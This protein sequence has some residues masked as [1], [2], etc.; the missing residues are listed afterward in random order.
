V[1]D[2]YRKIVVG[3]NKKMNLV[4]RRN[5]EN[6]LERLI[7]ESLLP[8]KWNVCRLASPLID[9]GSGAGIP[10]VPL[11]IEKPGLKLTLTDA[12]RR[13]SLFLKR[14]ID[15]LALEDVE[16][17]N[18]RIENVCSDGVYKHRFGTMTSRAV[19]SLS[20]LMNWGRFLLKPGG[21]LIVWKGSSLADEMAGLDTNGW[22][23]A[24]MWRQA[25]GL[26]LVR[27]VRLRGNAA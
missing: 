1:L 5:V 26:T 22:E 12:N 19:G 8:L 7:E 24:D 3:A 6:L 14:V 21:E 18:E 10:A 27:F 13:K 23:G 2:N 11:K 4:S 17:I 9:I 20:G 16:V 15:Q 25:N